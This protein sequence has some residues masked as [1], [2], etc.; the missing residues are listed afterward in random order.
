[1]SVSRA[2]ES[3]ED[4][5]AN[6]SSCKVCIVLE[7]GA[8]KSRGVMRGIVNEGPFGEKYKPDDGIGV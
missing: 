3:R 7:S 8:S 6:K 1:M 5:S 2:K 4:E